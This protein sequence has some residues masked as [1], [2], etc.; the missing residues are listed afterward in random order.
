MSVCQ[1]IAPVTDTEIVTDIEIDIESDGDIDEGN[2]C[3]K[4][5]CEEA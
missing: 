4:Q 1:G 5:K 3:K 2:P